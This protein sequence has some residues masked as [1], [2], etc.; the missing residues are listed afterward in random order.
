MRGVPYAEKVLDHRLIED[1]GFQRA[2]PVEVGLLSRLEAPQIAVPE[3]YIVNGD[4]RVVTALQRAVSGPTLAD[5]LERRPRGLGT[6]TTALIAHDL[7]TGLAAVHKL[8]VPH[9]NCRAEH[10]VIT[11]SGACVL[12]DA[13]LAE[14]PPDESLGAAIA[15]DLSA[16]GKVIELC[17]GGRAH[18]SV[19]LLGALLDC[20]SNPVT[21]RIEA[22]SGLLAD[23]GAGTEASFSGDWSVRARERLAGFVSGTGGSTFIPTPGEPIHSVVPASCRSRRQL[24]L[25]AGAALATVLAGVTITGILR[26]QA[27]A[28]HPRLTG[29]VS[30]AVPPQDSQAIASSFP[31]SAAP[32]RSM[33]SAPSHTATLSRSAVPSPGSGTEQ[34]ETATLVTGVS[35]ASFGYNGL[36]PTLA[37]TVVDVTTSG[38]GP[39]VLS[40]TFTGSDYAGQAGSNAPLTDRFELSGK[41]S[42]TVSDQTYGAQFC[43]T[44]YW[45]V[46]AVTSPRA[47]VAQTRQ[48]VSPSCTS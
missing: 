11:Q 45:S 41:T 7:L 15:A 9:R 2:Y 5:V 26:H 43:Y 40:L 19:P 35:I 8:G 14:R 39:L 37:E 38:T 21:A 22:A 17:L 42:Y 16:L 20:G 31:A 25:A 12:M 4:G 36:E 46:T 18:T 29:R 34:A 44:A 33:R 23:L 32:R 6:Q 13:G 28:A 48:L 10:V 3:G 27:L 24:V 30:M 47:P 1:G